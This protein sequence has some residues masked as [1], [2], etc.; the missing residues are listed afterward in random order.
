MTEYCT[1]LDSYLLGDLSPADS[2]AFDQHLDACEECHEAIEE[3]RW[4]DGL[5]QAAPQLESQAAPPGISD[6]WRVAVARRESLH[7]RIAA[8]TLAAAAA[9]L[10]AATWYLNHPASNTPKQLVTTIESTVA[11]VPPRAIFAAGNNAI[12]VPIKSTHPDV[13]IVRVYQS[14]QPANDSKVAALEPESKNPNNSI[15]SSNGG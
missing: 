1:N 6:G 12:V 11:Q 8:T 3:Q 9:L 10:I 14:F 13:T 4:I 15:N 2:K 7:T 5:L